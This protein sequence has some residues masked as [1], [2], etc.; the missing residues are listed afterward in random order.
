MI[1]TIKISEEQEIT[2]NTSMGWFS[3][4]RNQFGH[5][6]LPDL[7]PIV[8]TVL[9]L[10]VDQLGAIKDGD[11]VTEAIGKIDK[12]SLNESLTNLFGLEFA[13]V[14]NITWALVKNADD[15]TEAPEQWMNKLD[16]LP[17]DII[18]PEAGG[19]IVQSLVSSKNWKRLQG[20]VKK[21]VKR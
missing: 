2:I 9:N 20:A 10:V 18:V 21:V 6:I 3:I 4:Y 14:L 17:L 8:E 5:D 15:S 19:A 1:K 7:L 12:D 16:A 11:S 13:T